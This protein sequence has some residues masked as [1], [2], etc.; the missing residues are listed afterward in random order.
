MTTAAIPE[1]S[2]TPAM[3]SCLPDPAIIPLQSPGEDGYSGTAENRRAAADRRYQA[4][5]LR[6]SR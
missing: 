6:R 4:P 5:E 2:M 1:G 3:G